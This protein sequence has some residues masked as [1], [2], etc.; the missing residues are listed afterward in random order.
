M[1][2]LLW[3]RLNCDCS[4]TMFTIGFQYWGYC[5]YSQ[6]M[7]ALSPLG[8]RQAGGMGHPVCHSKN[9]TIFR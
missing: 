4:F 9:M 2:T 3:N 8:C 7:I 1:F 5:R 6:M